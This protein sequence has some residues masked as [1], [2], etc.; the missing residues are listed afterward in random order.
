MQTTKLNVAETRSVSI[1]APPTVVLR[2][3]ADARRLPEWAPDF[4]RA[5]RPDG[6][7]WLVDTGGGEARITP[8]RRG[9]LVFGQRREDAAERGLLPLP[10][11][12]Q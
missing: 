8:C 5:V 2:L 1:A 4:A 10:E 6:T 12:G 7:D 11:T 3:V 9:G